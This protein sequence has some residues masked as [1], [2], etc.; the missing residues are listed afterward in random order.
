MADKKDPTL[1]DLLRIFNKGNAQLQDKLKRTEDTIKVNQK[2]VKDFIRINDE[3][4]KDLLDRVGKLEKTVKTMEAT[5]TKLL[6]DMG[7]L[8]K[9]KTSNSQKIADMAKKWQ[10]SMSHRRAY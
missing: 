9:D 10:V 4:I 3:N 7:I 6:D 1:D 5:V 8:R 2:V